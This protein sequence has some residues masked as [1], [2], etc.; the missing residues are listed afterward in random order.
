MSRTSQD[1]E[2]NQD[3]FSLP[4]I[5]SQ[6]MDPWTLNTSDS[7]ESSPMGTQPETPEVTMLSY[8][9]SQ[10][11]MPNATTGL[12][13]SGAMFHSISD[14]QVAGGLSDHA[15]MD[16]SQSHHFAQA[17]ATSFFDYNYD[18]DEVAQRCTQDDAVSLGH[19]SVHE[20]GQLF[21]TQ[22]TWNLSLDT[23]NL[24]GAHYDQISHIY[25]PPVSPPLTEAGQASIPTACPQPAYFQVDEK[26]NAQDSFNP[27]SPPLN[28]QDPNRF[29]RTSVSQKK[30]TIGHNLAKC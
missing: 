25:S 19:D 21:S 4:A 30:N 2:M 17:I 26:T 13:D 14:L 28:D 8:S 9:F 22:E 18:N 24:V 29:V 6:D 5:H 23:S 7:L 10:Q 27:L 20:D 15:D 11:L 1:N 12:S 3:H 16:F